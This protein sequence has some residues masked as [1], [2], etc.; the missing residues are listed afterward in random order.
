M[1]ALYQSELTCLELLA[2]GKVRDIYTVDDDH[3]LIG[4][5]RQDLGI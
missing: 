1:N 3:L 2:R 4:R 5:H